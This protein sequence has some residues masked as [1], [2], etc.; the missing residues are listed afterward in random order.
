MLQDRSDLDPE[1]GTA[2]AHEHGGHWVNMEIVEKMP[3]QKGDVAGTHSVF[4]CPGCGTEIRY[5]K[6]DDHLPR[7]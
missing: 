5:E 6:P 2:L 1:T 4:R 7:Q 3:Y